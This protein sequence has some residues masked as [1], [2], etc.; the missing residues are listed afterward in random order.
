[1]AAKSLYISSIISHDIRGSIH[2]C[3]I[4]RVDKF[5]RRA[6][7]ISDTDL[8]QLMTDSIQQI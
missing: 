7:S 1:M 2:K 6:Q 8:I 3:N 4:G 5:P